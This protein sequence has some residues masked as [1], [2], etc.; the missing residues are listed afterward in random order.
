MSPWQGSSCVGIFFIRLGA[1]SL[2]GSILNGRQSIGIEFKS[3]YA[4]LLPALSRKQPRAV[5]KSS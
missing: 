2:M 3:V 4:G 1:W 5:A